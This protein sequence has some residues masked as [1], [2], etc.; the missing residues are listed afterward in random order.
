MNGLLHRLARQVVGPPPLRVQAMA[1]L[2]FFAPPELKSD[3]ASGLDLA[4]EAATP[5]RAPGSD[6]LEHDKSGDPAAQAALLPMPPPRM[7]AGLDASSDASPARTRLHGHDALGPARGPAQGAQSEAL[8]KAGQPPAMTTGAHAQAPTLR[9]SVQ[10]P[11]QSGAASGERVDQ[12]VATIEIITD[13]HISASGPERYPP[14]LL[15]RAEPAAPPAG[16]APAAPQGW[17]T[18][19][20]RRPR[21]TLPTKCT[22]TSAASRSRRSQ[23]TPAPKRPARGRRPPISLDEYLAR[24]HGGHR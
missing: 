15:A 17:P 1:R 3:D 22:S 5:N 11:P 20:R 16:R 14:P 19:V 2:P 7:A 4:A 12:G 13:S 24:R 18:C 8:S 21:P 9:V 23:E 6:P 10:S